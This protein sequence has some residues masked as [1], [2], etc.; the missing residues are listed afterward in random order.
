MT[1]PKGQAV[2]DKELG[3]FLSLRFGRLCA[4]LRQREP[5]DDIGY[6]ILIYDLTAKDIQDALFGPPVWLDPTL[7]PVP[8]PG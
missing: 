6:S 7:G 5:D 3:E 4:F 2:W 8:D 1:Q